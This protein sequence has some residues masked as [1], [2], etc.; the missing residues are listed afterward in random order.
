MKRSALSYSP[1]IC[2]SLLAAALLSACT[3]PQPPQAEHRPLPPAVSVPAG[4]PAA[5]PAPA[6]IPPPLL[7]APAPLSQL[8]PTEWSAIGSW[9]Q[10]RL[11]DAWPAFLQSCSGLKSQP[12][13]QAVC[14]DAQS[15]DGSNEASVR[16][17]FER[18]FRP[19]EVF[20]ADNSLE[21]TITGYYE[22]LIQGARTP[23]DKAR[24]PLYA[25]PDDLIVVDLA[26]VY[27]ELKSMRL[28]GRLQ[29]NRIVPYYTRSEIENANGGFNGQPIAWADDAVELFFLQ[30]Q[31]SGRIELPDGSHLRV[32]YAEQNGHPYRSIGKLL[33][34]RGDLK[35][36]EASMQGIKAWG[37][38][39]PDKLPELLNSNPSYVFFKELP[40]G[41]SGPL[42]ALGVPLS[43]GRSIAI[44]PKY[45]PL[46]APVFLATTYPNSGQPLDRL[47]MAQD[48]GG[49][50]RGAVRADLFWGFGADAGEQAGKMKQKG[51]MWVLL[52]RDYPAPANAAR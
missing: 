18:R 29:R 50:I 16:S 9:S 31:G 22:P 43:A 40:N 27:P 52:P 19:H 37:A 36:E 39:N 33:V 20:N 38:A 49:A 3:T 10:D 28:R 44:D 30:I 2:A 26:S 11:K 48:T 8:R 35:L 12:A 47:M 25:I 42:G 32:G 46:G 15:L 21:G 14:S 41:L 5:E 7:P 24:Y 17:F 6:Q 34:E 51:R 45:V 4:P 23:G 1:G 13:W